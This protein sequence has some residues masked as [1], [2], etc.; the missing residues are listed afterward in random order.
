MQEIGATGVLEAASQWDWIQFVDVTLTPS[1]IYNLHTTPI[2]IIPA[3]WAGKY[4][5]YNQLVPIMQVTGTTAYNNTLNIAA[6][7]DWILPSFG[8]WYI[9][10]IWPWAFD[11][12]WFLW[13]PSGLR[14]WQS[15]NSLYGSSYSFVGKV[16]PTSYFENKS[17]KLWNYNSG[18]VT[19]PTLGDQTFTT[20]LYYTIEDVPPYTPIPENVVTD[21]KVEANAA[22]TYFPFDG[23]ETDLDVNFLYNS[24]FFDMLPWFVLN[25][26]YEWAGVWNLWQFTGYEITLLSTQIKLTFTKSGAKKGIS[27]VTTLTK[28]SWALTYSAICSVA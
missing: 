20:R 19:P 5:W 7:F 3:P 2:E 6:Y 24:T 13:T 10:K 26:V 12:L 11:S 28:T 21:I 27:N 16:N 17:V 15:P 1:E 14:T 22:G 9:Y 4:I 25:P 18:A 8:L 23:T